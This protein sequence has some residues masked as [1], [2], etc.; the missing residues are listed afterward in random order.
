MNTENEKKDELNI[1]CQ[2]TEEQG[3]NK[4]EEI[5][6]IVETKDKEE[7]KSNQAKESTATLELS[8]KEEVSDKNDENKIEEKIIISEVKE[9]KIE[10]EENNENKPKVTEGLT[11]K[12]KLEVIESILEGEQNAAK[13]LSKR[14]SVGIL[15]LQALKFDNKEGTITPSNKKE[16]NQ[17]GN[18]LLSSLYEIKED[19]N[20]D[21]TDSKI[22]LDNKKEEKKE[23]AK[24]EIKEENKEDKKDD[25]KPNLMVTKKA[26]EMRR[27]KTDGYLP[28]FGGGDSKAAEERRN[29]MAKRLNKAKQ[30]AKQNEEKNKYRKSIDIANKANFLQTKISGKIEDPEKK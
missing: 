8:K 28:S 18:D 7:L 11:E 6:E 12:K 25:S 17:Q 13:K 30:V 23:E 20:E 10:K 27:V 19:R 3:E 2:K 15:G 22:I 14:S 26:K 21:I 24:G 1:I 29:R 4:K 9:K 16:N 5:I